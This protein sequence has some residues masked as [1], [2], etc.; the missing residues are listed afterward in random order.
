VPIDP[1]ALDPALKD[2]VADSRPGQLH[3]DVRGTEKQANPEQALVEGRPT[4]LERSAPTRRR[5]RRADRTLDVT[6][7]DRHWS[8]LHP[9]I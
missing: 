1:A 8:T 7:T 5:G 9:Q 6:V 3:D 2:A 4:P